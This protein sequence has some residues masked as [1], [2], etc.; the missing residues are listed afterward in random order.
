MSRGLP[1]AA[2]EPSPGETAS[3]SISTAWPGPGSARVS[4]AGEID[5]S[6][7]QRL[8]SEL[9]AVIVAAPPGADVR[10]D[11]AGVTFV[12][13]TGIGVLI[14]ANQAARR[15]GIGFAVA[16]PTGVVRRIIDVLDLAGTLLAPDE[17]ADR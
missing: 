7:A 13:A 4:L 17:P 3:L 10:V 12:D 8:R 16:N 15:A 14:R 11:L 1:T 6:T 9:L 5:L 2:T